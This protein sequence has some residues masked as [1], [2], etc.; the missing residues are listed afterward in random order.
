MGNLAQERYRTGNRVEVYTR[1]DGER[2]LL[3]NGLTGRLAEGTNLSGNVNT[4]AR[5]LHV[6]GSFSP[7]D[8]VDG[9][10]TYDI[11]LSLLNLVFRGAADLINAAPVDIDIIDR[12]GG[13]RLG[14]FEE[15]HLTSGSLQVPAN[16]P[17]VRDLSFKAL[18]VV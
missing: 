18:R 11:R 16:Q 3:G 6:I 9:A 15:C 13:S 12:E 1:G 5:E 8:I 17:I 2:K 4:G 10:H 7:V 14:T